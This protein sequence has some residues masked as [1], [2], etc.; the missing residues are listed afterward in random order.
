[1]YCDFRKNVCLI[2]PVE[3]TFKF[4][5]SVV[6][7]QWLS[8]LPRRSIHAGY[9][10][11]DFTV[12]SGCIYQYQSLQATEDTCLQLYSSITFVSYLQNLCPLRIHPYL[13][14]RTHFCSFETAR[15]LATEQKSLHRYKILLSS[16]KVY[17]YPSLCAFLHF[18]RFLLYNLFMTE[19]CYMDGRALLSLAKQHLFILTSITPWAVLFGSTTNHYPIFSRFCY[20]APLSLQRR[21][22]SCP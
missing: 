15:R 1:M 22:L 13:F 17:F 19:K 6:R 21:D 11:T 5:F 20:S 3:D 2:W 18:S 14:A 16:F 4:G 10:K 12:C 8:S 9:I 7:I